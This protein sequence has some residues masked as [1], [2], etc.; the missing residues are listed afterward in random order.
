MRPLVL[1]TALS[2]LGATASARELPYLL[3]PQARVDEVTQR[4]DEEGSWWVR[5]GDKVFSPAFGEGGEWP[6]DSSPYRIALGRDLPPHLRE[7]VVAS[8]NGVH[9]LLEPAG[10]WLPI[11]RTPEDSLLGWSLCRKFD[12]Q[13]QPLVSGAEFAVPFRPEELARSAADDGLT[14]AQIQ[15]LVD[16]LSNAQY[17]ARV[18][19]LTAFGS[20]H[21]NYQGVLN[22]RDYIAS[23]F[24]AFG[25][26]AT[27]PS[28]SVGQR[29]AYNVVG[30]LEGTL[31]PNEIL[32]IGAHYDSLP[33]SQ[34]NAPGAEDNASGT[35]AVIELARILSAFG[36][37]RTIY[38]VAFGGEEQGLVGSRALVNGLT[39]TQRANLKGA[40]TMDMISYTADSQID[41][42][43]ETSSAGFALRTE[44]ARAAAD[45]TDLRVFTSNNPF[46]S[47]H[48][49]FLNA[50]LP[51]LL[52]IEN[53]WDVYPAYHTSNDRVTNLNANQGGEIARM[54]LG[55]AARIANPQPAPTLS[56]QQWTIY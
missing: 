37:Q 7:D 50:S 39:S 53:D 30:V 8:A 46:G 2:L 42:L 52:L 22:A 32:L 27:T 14:I 48:V 5:V 20:R 21:T 34:T 31:F 11:P 49:S 55:A 45:F 40:I 28:F 1:L 13:L 16:Q 3:V 29:T 47:D 51:S 10:E 4:L 9:I 43:L 35:A 56:V 25:L 44:L 17:I 15:V 41:V 26:T 33:N 24:Q 18:S 12:G 6:T 23:E 54:A 38:F 19:A 36:S